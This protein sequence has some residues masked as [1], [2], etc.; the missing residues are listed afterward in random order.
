MVH[1]DVASS[2]CMLVPLCGVV[3]REY[4]LE[5]SENVEVKLIRAQV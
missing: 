2:G 3:S 5:V 4:N 1:E